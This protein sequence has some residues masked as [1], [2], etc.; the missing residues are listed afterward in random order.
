MVRL[1]TLLRRRQLLSILLVLVTHGLLAIGRGGRIRAH[2]GWRPDITSTATIADIGGDT[3][4]G[5][6]SDGV[7]MRPMNM[8]LGI[9]IDR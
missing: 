8:D 9:G 1:I 4:A 3:S 5:S 7:G 2:I 6:A